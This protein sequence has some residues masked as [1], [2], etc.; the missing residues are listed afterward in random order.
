MSALCIDRASPNGYV[1]D[2]HGSPQVALGAWDGYAPTSRRDRGCMTQIADDGYFFMHRSNMFNSAL[3]ARQ[4]IG[5]RSTMLVPKIMT[6]CSTIRPCFTL[7]Q[8]ALSTLQVTEHHAKPS[9]GTICDFPIAGLNIAKA[10]RTP[11]F[12]HKQ[13]ALFARVLYMI[14]RTLLSVSVLVT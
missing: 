5:S 11:R 10:G 7:P 2:A 6:L 12:S 9:C 3:Y 8:R 14:L 13:V 1:C 4:P